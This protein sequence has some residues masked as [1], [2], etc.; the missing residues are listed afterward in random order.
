MSL[1]DLLENITLYQ[2][3]GI[4]MAYIRKAFGLTDN[5]IAIIRKYPQL[6]WDTIYKEMRGQKMGSHHHLDARGAL[7]MF[8]LVSRF[9]NQVTPVQEYLD[10]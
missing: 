2:R 9:R 8:G 3:N 5:E 1:D 10:L 4:S 6:A 7:I